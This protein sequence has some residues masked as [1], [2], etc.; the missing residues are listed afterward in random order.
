MRS[1]WLQLWTRDSRSRVNRGMSVLILSSFD[2]CPCRWKKIFKYF[3][4]SSLGRLHCRGWWVGRQGCRRWKLNLGGSGD[5]WGKWGP[6]RTQMPHPAALLPSPT[7]HHN[8]LLFVEPALSIIVY[9]AR[10]VWQLRR[11]YLMSD[12]AIPCPGF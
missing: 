3:G 2:T 10:Y 11:M 7:D 4:R 9:I 6:A 1:D 8:Q 12:W 5:V